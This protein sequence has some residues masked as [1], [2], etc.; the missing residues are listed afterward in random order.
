M[1]NS[2]ENLGIVQIERS[3]DEDG[4][5]EELFKPYELANI[6]NKAFGLNNSADKYDFPT[7]KSI[8]VYFARCG[9]KKIQLKIIAPEPLKPT[10]RY[11]GYENRI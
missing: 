9:D 6:V 4:Q 11:W 7:I 5:L 3:C 10:S 8:G 2:E 1:S